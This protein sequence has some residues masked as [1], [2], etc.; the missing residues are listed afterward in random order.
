MSYRRVKRNTGLRRSGGF[1]FVIQ[2]KESR[3]ILAGQSLLLP[4]QIDWPGRWAR[5][6]GEKGQHY[7]SDKIICGVFAY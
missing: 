1:L 4:T 7:D 3:G 6:I 2:E 5:M